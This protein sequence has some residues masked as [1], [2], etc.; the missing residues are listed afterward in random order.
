MPKQLPIPPCVFPEDDDCCYECEK[1]V[2]VP[3]RCFVCGTLIAEKAE[4]FGTCVAPLCQLC[5]WAEDVLG[6]DERA[7][8]AR[9]GY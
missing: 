6:A 5:L 3:V 2:S 8:Q 4:L 1:M 9:Y 7:H